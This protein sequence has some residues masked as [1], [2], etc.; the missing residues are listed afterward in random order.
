M[1]I[2]NSLSGPNSLCG[3]EP[4]WW[5]EIRRTDRADLQI[6]TPRTWGVNRKPPLQLALAPQI[7]GKTLNLR[8]FLRPPP[9]I[10][11]VL[12]CFSAHSEDGDNFQFPDVQLLAMLKRSF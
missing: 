5:P 8:S 10:L 4:L 3:S 1:V 12:P 7:C 6:L 9:P 11:N 2:L